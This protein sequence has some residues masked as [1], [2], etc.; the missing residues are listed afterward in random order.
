[1]SAIPPFFSLLTARALL[2]P[3]EIRQTDDLFFCTSVSLA[4]ILCRAGIHTFYNAQGEA[5]RCDLFFDDWYL[6]A[7]TQEEQTVYSLFKMREQE[8]DEGLIADADTP[9]VTVCF[10]AFSENILSA[11]LADPS[12][13]HLQALDAEISR[14]VAR[15]GQKHHPLIKRYFVR[16]QA[17]A[18][19]LIARM[20][21][22]HITSFAREGVLP[23]PGRY[24]QQYRRNRRLRV[25]IDSCSRSAGRMICDHKSIFL[26]DPACPSP[27]ETAVL[28]ATHTANTSFHSFAAEI[29]FHARFLIKPL[30]LPL[31]F[32]KKTFYDSAVRADMTI[33][34]SPWHSLFPFYHPRSKCIRQQRVYHQDV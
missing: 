26:S 16:A 4:Q 7:V 30:R 13:E 3:Q 18:P 6:Y 17:Q 29:C 25:F 8:A 20:Y 33:D 9:G 5:R 11:C 2:A 23:V 10:I 19:Y 1:M 21:I 24:A 15:R 22:R 27:E 32:S 28:L 14:V 12:L 31:P 34:C